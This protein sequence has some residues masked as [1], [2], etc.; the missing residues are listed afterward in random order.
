MITI[1]VP[2]EAQAQGRPRAYLQKNGRIGVYDPKKSRDYKA[3]FRW[4]AAQVAPPTPLEGPCEVEVTVYRPI[5]KSMPKYKRAL[6]EAGK[7]FP[8][9]KPDVDNYIKAVFD[10]LNNLIWRDDSQ[11]YRLTVAKLYSDQPRVEVRVKEVPEGA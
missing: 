8:T 6:V 2:G 4:C 11:V 5:P 3:F 9:T 7:L 1:I 10:S